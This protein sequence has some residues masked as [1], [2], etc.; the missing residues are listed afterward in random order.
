MPSEIAREEEGELRGCD[1]GYLLR[2]KQGARMKTGGPY[3]IQNPGVEL[4]S[5]MEPLNASP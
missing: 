3:K 1:R 4:L 2:I 5:G